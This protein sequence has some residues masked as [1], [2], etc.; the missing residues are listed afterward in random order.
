MEFSEFGYKTLQELTSKDNFM[1]AAV[2]L[3]EENAKGVVERATR[4]MIFQLYLIRLRIG[5]NGTICKENIRIR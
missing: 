1:F 4:I 3:D 5:K 2:M